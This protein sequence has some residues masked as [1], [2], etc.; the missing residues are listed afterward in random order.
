MDLNPIVPHRGRKDYSFSSLFYNIDDV[1]IA[2]E[3]DEHEV[4]VLD[5]FLFPITKLSAQNPELSDKPT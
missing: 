1:L 5:L 3:C 2:Y 4:G